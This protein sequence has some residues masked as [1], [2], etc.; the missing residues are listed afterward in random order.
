MISGTETPGL[1]RHATRCGGYG[2]VLLWVGTANERYSKL[3]L[4]PS[5]FTMPTRGRPHVP[6]R[7]VA[8]WWHVHAALRNALDVS[9]QQH[10]TNEELLRQD[11]LRNASVTRTAPYFCRSLLAVWGSAGKTSSLVG[12]YSWKDAQ[13][14]NQPHDVRQAAAARFVLWDDWELQQ[15]MKNRVE[16]ARV[17]HTT[18]SSEWLRSLRKWMDGLWI[19]PCI[20]QNYSQIYATAQTQTT[21]LVKRFVQMCC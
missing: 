3:Q 9:W 12:G 1:G 20:P 10:M 17:S 2:C 14:T 16:W 19:R 4:G 11:T 6:W 8:Y 5:C 21:A 18:S 15:M 7:D 13:K